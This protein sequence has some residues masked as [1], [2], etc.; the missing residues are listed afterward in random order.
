MNHTANYQLNQWEPGDPV[1]HTDFNEDNRKIEAALKDRNIRVFLDYYTGTGSGTKTQSY[2][3]VPVMQILTGGG[4]CLLMARPATKAVCWSGTGKCGV[5][6]VTW[7]ESGLSWTTPNKDYELE[8]N[9][10]GVTYACI[11]FMTPQ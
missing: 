6:D 9:A 11:T 8:C 2:Y 1:L 10:K 7:T 5:V 3:R 4:F